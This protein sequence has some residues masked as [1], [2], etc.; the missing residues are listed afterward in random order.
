MQQKFEALNRVCLNNWHYI[1]RRVLS[2]PTASISLPATLEVESPPSLTLCR[3]C[4]M[5]IQT[6]EDFSI[7]RQLMI[8]TV[9]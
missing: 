7:K 4:C 1:D 9:P 5:P 2:F 8:P 3:F 6:E